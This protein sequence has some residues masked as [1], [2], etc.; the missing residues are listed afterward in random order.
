[1]AAV[2]A[3]RL[4]PTLDDHN[5]AFWTGGRDGQ[6]LIQRCEACARWV[7]PPR[8]SCP[9]CGGALRAEP[10]RGTGTVFTY[11][12]NEQQFR[13]E[14]TPPYVIAI[15]VLDEQGDLRLPTNIVGC[16]PEDVSVDLRVRVVFEQQ[17]EIFVP[18]FT[19]AAS[20]GSTA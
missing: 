2:T 8:A 14:V 17:G 10:V 16:A 1:L 9:A 13:P 5:R 18:L 15:V 3:P 4:L 11:T 19:P 12:I 6:L 7:H 20:A